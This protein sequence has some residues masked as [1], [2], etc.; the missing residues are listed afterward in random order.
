MRANCDLGIL[1]GVCCFGLIGPSSAECEGPGNVREI[2]STRALRTGSSLDAGVSRN[3]RSGVTRLGAK[4]ASAAWR[5]LVLYRRSWSCICDRSDKSF[6]NGLATREIRLS[7]TLQM[8]F[9][10]LDAVAIIMFSIVI[11]KWQCSKLHTSNTG[12]LRKTNGAFLP[13]AKFR[14]S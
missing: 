7:W 10:E 2:A 3:D 6:S 8:S 12:R 1:G 14:A 13:S 9:E 4:S 5:A 11:K